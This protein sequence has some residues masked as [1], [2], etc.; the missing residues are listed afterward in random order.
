MGYNVFVRRTLLILR[1]GKSEWGAEYGS[2]FERPLAKRGRKAAKFMGGYIAKQGYGP[3]L[4]VS[5]PANRALSTA[6]LVQKELDDVELQQDE[7]VYMA[8]H[9]DL[10]DVLEGV[11]DNLEC[12]LVVGH[13]PGLEDLVADLCG[14]DDAFLRTCSLAVIKLGKCSWDNVASASGKLAGLFHPRELM[15][16][17]NG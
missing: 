17:T 1:H 13:N 10:Y 7:R 3:R 15:E 8:D 16:H 2:D 14:S 9:E 11:P 12:V 5:S 6:K 4:V